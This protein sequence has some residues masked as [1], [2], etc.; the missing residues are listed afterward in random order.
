MLFIEEDK[1]FIK[2]F[3]TDYGY[4]LRKLIRESPDK[5]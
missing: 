1:T 5:E 2:I 4:G 3:V